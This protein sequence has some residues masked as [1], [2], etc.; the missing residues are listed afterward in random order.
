MGTCEGSLQLV[1]GLDDRPVA[2]HVSLRR[3]HIE[4]LTTGQSAQQGVKRQHS[5]LLSHQLVH[6]F[7]AE[8]IGK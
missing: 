2:S 7:Y 3:E 6:Q 5:G 4:G 1:G 8:I